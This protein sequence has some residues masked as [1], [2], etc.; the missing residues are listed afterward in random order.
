MNSPWIASCSLKVREWFASGLECRRTSSLSTPKPQYKTITLTFDY[1]VSIHAWQQVHPFHFFPA[2]IDVSTG[3][4]TLAH[5]QQLAD[6]LWQGA[7][8]WSQD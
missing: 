3:W 1:Y 7:V 5:F 4:R 8:G 6:L 2:L